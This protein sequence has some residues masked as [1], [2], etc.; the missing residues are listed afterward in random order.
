MSEYLM[1]RSNGV[2]KNGH[3]GNAVSVVML[4]LIFLCVVKGSP[5]EKGVV[6][7][8]D[9]GEQKD[10][11]FSKKALNVLNMNSGNETFIEIAASGYRMISIEEMEAEVGP[12]EENGD[13][14]SLAIASCVLHIYCKE[15]PTTDP[16]PL[17]YNTRY[18][19][20]Y[21]AGLWLGQTPNAENIIV[22]EDESVR[23]LRECQRTS[24]DRVLYYYRKGGSDCSAWGPMYSYA[25][26]GQALYVL[27]I[28]KYAN[29]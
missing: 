13:G 2:T 8:F 19:I 12:L 1:N 25:S 9:S 18:T 5:H 16:H 17:W 3:S 11:K 23:V 4:M 21:V 29:L 6:E 14:R 26:A 22:S 7:T 28:F 15:Q 10:S 24:E 27:S 20:D